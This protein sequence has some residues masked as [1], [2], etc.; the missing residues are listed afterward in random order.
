MKKKRVRF[1]MVIKRG[2]CYTKIYKDRKPSGT[3]FRV[4]YQLGGKRHRLSFND[5][6]KATDEAEAKAAQLSRGDVDAMQIYGRDRLIYGRAL[7]AIKET[8][9]AL[10]AAAIEYAQS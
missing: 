1:P 7:D 4:V 10:D 5:L 6:Q 2:S 3:Y 8:G 9:V